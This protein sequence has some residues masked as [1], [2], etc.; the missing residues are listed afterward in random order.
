MSKFTEVAKIEELKN[1]TMKR[2]IVGGA[3]SSSPKPEITTMP[4]I[5]AVP[6]G[7]VIYHRVNWKELWSL[8]P[9]MALNLISVMARWCAG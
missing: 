8:V 4:P 9:C 1:R 5:I 2:V 6:I 3:K 7:R